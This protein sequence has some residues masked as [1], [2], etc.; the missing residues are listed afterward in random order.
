[1]KYIGKEMQRSKISGSRY[2]PRRILIV[3]GYNVINA[4]GSLKKKAEDDLEQARETLISYIL[5]Y[6]KIKGYE[7][8]VVFDAYNVKGCDETHENHH[9]VNVIFT[10]ENQT[11][12][13]YIEM[14][15]S[16]LSKYDEVAVATSDY[17]EQQIVLGKGC[18]RISSR[19]L[20]EGLNASKEEI[21]KSSLES[22]K[23]YNTMNRLENRIDSDIF[24]KLERIRRNK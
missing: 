22:V 17:A 20:I 18:T 9:G 8:Y 13:S 11:A 4:W 2:N 5:E 10:K 19:E 1:M 16:K 21:R 23:K 3:D 6:S 24:D 14:F 7:V 15:I 12:D